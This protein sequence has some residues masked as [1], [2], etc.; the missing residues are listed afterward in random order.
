[1]GKAKR[2][3]M[4]AKLEREQK[5]LENILANLP[6]NPIAWGPIVRILGPIIARLAVRIALKKSKRHMSEAKVNQVADAVSSTISSILAKK[7]I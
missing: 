6:D 1:M 5:E 2:S 4:E 7:G 3:S